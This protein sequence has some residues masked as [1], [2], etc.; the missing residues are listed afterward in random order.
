M[1]GQYGVRGPTRVGSFLEEQ[2]GQTTR[3]VP[4]DCTRVLPPSQ[5]DSDSTSH[6]GLGRVDARH[7]TQGP[8][9][10]TQETVRTEQVSS[11]MTCHRTRVET[12][13]CETPSLGSRK[14]VSLR[15]KS[16]QC[17]GKSKH[18]NTTIVGGVSCQ[19]SYFYSIDYPFV[20]RVPDVHRLQPREENGEGHPK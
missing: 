19:F 20:N 15:L 16:V 10:T 11:P 12:S 9:R 7:P 4:S 17:V 6:T 3:G 18:V 2:T 13:R 5:L 14:Q 1:V 8:I